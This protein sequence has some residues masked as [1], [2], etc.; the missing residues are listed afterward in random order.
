VTKAGWSTRTQV[1]RKRSA[2]HDVLAASSYVWQTRPSPARLI[3]RSPPG[4]LISCNNGILTVEL[5]ER[6]LILLE[7]SN[8]HG[9]YTRQIAWLISPG[10]EGVA[11]EGAATRAAAGAI[12]QR[13]RPVAPRHWLS[14]D[15]IGEWQGS[16]NFVKWRH[17]DPG[18][19]AP[20]VPKV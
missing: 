3:A 11:T 20:Q 8:S 5:L 18:S 4:G 2:R 15:T 7:A 10:T 9:R 13:P 1:G 12:D 16:G 17:E 14:A 6:H 19:K